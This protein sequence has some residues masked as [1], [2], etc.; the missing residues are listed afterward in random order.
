MS[1]SLPIYKTAKMLTE[2]QIYVEKRT[3]LYNSDLLKS[4]NAEYIL[5][6]LITFYVLL[7]GYYAIYF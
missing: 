7:Y 6:H 5:L 4:G 3:L 2:L 1:A